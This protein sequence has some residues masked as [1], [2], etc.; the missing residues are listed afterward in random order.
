MLFLG[1]Q[2]G[3]SL[4][5]LPY[6]SYPDGFLSCQSIASSVPNPLQSLHNVQLK[7]YCLNPTLFDRFSRCLTGTTIYGEH[8]KDLKL[9][10]I[11]SVGDLFVQKVNDNTPI[12]VTEFNKNVTI[13]SKI[14]PKLNYS[15]KFDM[16]SLWRL[17][18][19]DEHEE[20]NIKKNNVWSMSKEKMSS[21]V[22]HLAPI[23]LSPWDIDDL[24]EWENE[25]ENDAANDDSD[26]D[27]TT[28]VNFWFNKNDTLL[29]ST[30][31]LEPSTDHPPINILSQAST[32][33]TV[34]SSENDND[35][36]SGNIFLIKCLIFLFINI[37]FI[38]VTGFTVSLK[39][40]DS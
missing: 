9:F 15:Y 31:T 7:G 5:Y 28:K 20:I 19:P 14:V 26:C 17:D 22:D 39:S 23:I 12:N 10:S 36:S 21:Y 4:V 2:T 27:Y 35:S 13:K 33:K 38:L 3:E 30:E 11:N 24:S 18:S 34:P 1:N 32:A 8:I 29:K 25:D 6:T 37:V 16:S 40:D